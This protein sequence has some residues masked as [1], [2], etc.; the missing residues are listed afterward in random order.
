MEV[1]KPPVENKRRRDASLLLV[2]AGDTLLAEETLQGIMAKLGQQLDLATALE[3]FRA[4]EDATEAVLA[5]AETLPFGAE[6]RVVL[7]RDA[8]RLKEPDLALLKEYAANPVPTS[9]LLL[10]AVGLDRK[11]KLPSLFRKDQLVVVP[12]KKGDSLRRWLRQRFKERELIIT[13]RALSFI[14]ENSSGNLS[15]LDHIVDKLRLYYHG[16]EELDLEDV[17]PLVAPLAVAD[18]YQLPERISS[19]DTGAALK[20]VKRLFRQEEDAMRILFV[21][22]SHFRNLLGVKGLREEGLRRGE[23]QAQLKLDDWRYQRLLPYLQRYELFQLI[24]IYHRLMQTDLAIK[25]GRYPAELAIEMLVARI[26][27]KK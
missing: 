23:I 24:D 16:V 18:I 7:L 19:G 20:M 6:R 14:L 13:D 11:S 17:A 5:A 10:V 9:L 8:E 15:D 25:T 27:P 3:V 21:L 2:Q 12:Q 26:T 4:G 1:A 22:V